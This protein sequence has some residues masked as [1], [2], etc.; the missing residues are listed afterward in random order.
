MGSKG[1]SSRTYNTSLIS[2]NTRD[3]FESF[4]NYSMNSADFLKDLG[5]YRGNFIAKPDPRQQQALGIMESQ[6][7]SRLGK[8]FGTPVFNLGEA[9][10]RGDYLKPESNPYLRDYIRMGND[11]L[12][13]SWSTTVMPRLRAG[14]TAVGADLGTRQALVETESARNLQGQQKNF[15]L[16]A[17]MGNYGAERSRQTELGA[18]I[19][20]KGAELQDVP[21]SQLFGVGETAR[22]FK[23]E[24]INNLIMKYMAQIQGA[25]LPAQA[26]GPFASWI[27]AFSDSKIRVKS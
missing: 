16:E 8:N 1:G 27:P 5:P 22:S 18:D 23:Q 26:Y 25:L 13:R 17:L 24:K 15:E 19:Y 9:T 2:P 3:F 12:A 4:Q 6:A 20:G 7:R 21:A 14:S 11:E 10:V